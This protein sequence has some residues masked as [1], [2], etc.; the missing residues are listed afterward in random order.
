M[1]KLREQLR[2]RGIINTW[3]VLTKFGTKRNAIAVS[4]SRAPSGRMGYGDFNHAT[5]WS[6][7]F[8]TDPEEH[9]YNGK[10]FG[11]NRAKSIPKAVAWA[12]EKYGITEWATCPTDPSCKIP[13][14]L[15][16]AALAFPVPV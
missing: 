6:P 9:R 14:E 16:E 5:V 13:K 4:Y 15:R 7:F 12:T 10:V 3:D 1:S 8:K 11:G 2:A